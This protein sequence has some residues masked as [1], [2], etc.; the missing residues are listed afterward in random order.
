MKILHLG[1]LHIGKKVN[2]YSMIENQRDVFEQIYR[3][4]EEKKVETV[5]IA[6]DIY[7]RSVP[8]EEATETLDEFL[9]HLINTLQ[10]RVIAISGNHD[11]P[12]RLE[13][14]RG[15]LA[16]QGLHIVGEYNKLVNKVSVDNFD[17]YLMPFVTPA[18]IR[19][20]F[21]EVIEEREL[22]VSTYDDTMKFITGEAVAQL[23]RDRVNIALYHGFVIGSGEKEEDIEREESVK[24]LAVGG[25]E[26]V[27]E[28]YFLDFDYTALGHLH[29]NRRVKSERVRYSGSPIKY[30]FSERN[31]K[32]S[33]TVIDIDRDRFEVENI[34]I[35]DK[36]PMV[37]IKGTFDEVME[38]D[39]DSDAYLKVT[40]TETVLDAMNKLRT[41]YSQVMELGIEIATSDAVRKDHRS[42]NIDKVPTDELFKD[43]AASVG[44][45]LDEEEVEKVREI[46]N[47]IIKG[48]G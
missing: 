34:E 19:K 6:G 35:V 26:S 9:S 29:G 37:E 36:Y 21:G 11:S 16:K 32:K 1:D 23:D 28:K 12:A 44:V 27:A 17:F 31:Q 46:V 20:K 41:K 42:A 45:E 39:I 43:L 3:V 13:F 25:K 48:E 24:P 18:T 2:G 40:L 38:A 5:L 4:I 47:E 8:S 30:S 33:L 7:D 15:I 22:T 10:V 14:S